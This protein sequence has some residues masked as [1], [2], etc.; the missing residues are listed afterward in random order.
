MTCPICGCDAEHV[1]DGEIVR[2]ADC[3]ACYRSRV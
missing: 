1:D 3:G 2:C